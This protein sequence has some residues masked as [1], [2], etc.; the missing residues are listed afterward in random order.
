MITLP[1]LLTPH[2]G[3]NKV[4]ISLEQQSVLVDADEAQGAT[5]DAVLEK[6]KKTGRTVKGG[7][8]IA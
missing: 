8:T 3:V 1:C 5:Y 4:D 2:P 7:E 6:I